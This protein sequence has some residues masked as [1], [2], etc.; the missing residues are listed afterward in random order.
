M[1]I[2]SSANMSGRI[3]PG[4]RLEDAKHHSVFLVEDVRLVSDFV[5]L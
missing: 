1:E 2:A 3:L 5:A 4:D